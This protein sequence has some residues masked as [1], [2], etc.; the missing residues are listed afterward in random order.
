MSDG[1]GCRRRIITA[2]FLRMNRNGSLIAMN[3]TLPVRTAGER[4]KLFRF[5]TAHK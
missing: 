2:G 5:W 3:S 1:A 4:K